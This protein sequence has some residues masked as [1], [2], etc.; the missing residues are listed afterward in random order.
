MNVE[1]VEFIVEEPSM[2]ALLRCILPRLLG[3]IPFAI[4]PFQS[5]HDL[6]NELPK[7]LRGYRE[8]L[9]PGY[10]VVVL[11]DRDDDDCRVLKQQLEDAAAGAGLF[12]RS[13]PDG[14]RFSVINRVVV[15]ELEAW[16]FGDWDAVCAAYPRVTKT[17]IHK[18]GMRNPD[19]IEGGTW[20]TFQRML[21][22]AGY[23]RNGL[24]KIEAA[25][26]IGA[27][28]DVDRNTSR[29]FRALCDALRS[30]T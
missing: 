16:Y 25:R 22:Q 13:R 21:Q 19:A 7:R 17:A 8:W 12:T 11:V 30:L 1:F 10:R 9:P 3:D 5:K 4:F 27:H 26:T 28:M 6:L 18:R 2:E 14:V 23:F 15:E 29:S 24:R 20:E